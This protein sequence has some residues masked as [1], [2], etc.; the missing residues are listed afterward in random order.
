MGNNNYCQNFVFHS[1]LL[2]NQFDRHIEHRGLKKKNSITIALASSV[3]KDSKCYFL[4]TK[5]Q[6]APSIQ[7][8]T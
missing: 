2:I 5:E 7:C 4:C 6:K 1:G 8:A 3:L